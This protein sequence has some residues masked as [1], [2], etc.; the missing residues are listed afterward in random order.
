M[1]ACDC[2]AVGCVAAHEAEVGVIDDYLVG[3]RVEDR[4]R[5]I[6]ALT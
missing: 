2:G 6:A 3:H 1:K 4:L 5:L